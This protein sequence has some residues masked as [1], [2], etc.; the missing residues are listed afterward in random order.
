[1]NMFESSM[2]DSRRFAVLIIVIICGMSFVS[3]SPTSETLQ[4]L[5][6][7]SI[8]HPKD[9]G[10]AKTKEV[11]EETEKRTNFAI[12][13]YTCIQAKNEQEPFDTTKLSQKQLGLPRMSSDAAEIQNVLGSMPQ[14][15]LV[16]KLIALGKN[17]ETELSESISV[18]EIMKQKAKDSIGGTIGIRRG[19][20]SHVYS[21]TI[22]NLNDHKKKVGKE[23]AK[24]EKMKS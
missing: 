17:L 5:K 9:I 22:D 6:D 21:H 4:Q 8:T 13:F 14:P 11:K 12:V 2:L 15:T 19:L 24:L 3:S 7:G 10:D 16:E 23:V 18:Y 20:V 1:M